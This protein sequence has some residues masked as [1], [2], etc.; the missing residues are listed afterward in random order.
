MTAARRTGKRHVIRALALGIALAGSQLDTTR[1][2]TTERVVVDRHT[3]LALYGVDPVAYFTDR[4]PVPGRAEFEYRYAGAIWRFLNDG[5]RAAFAADP[6]VYMPLYGGYDPIGISRGLATPGFP[7]LWALHEERLYLFYTADA[8]AAF[9]ADP[10]TVIA[11]AS[12]RWTAVRS[13]LAE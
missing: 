10:A 12:A 13:E 6:D 5:N 9:L 8:R 1:A 11:A 2:T 4:K 3:G 7:A